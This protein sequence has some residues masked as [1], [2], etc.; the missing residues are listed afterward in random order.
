MGGRVAKAP[1]QATSGQIAQEA[2]NAAG[3]FGNTDPAANRSA[4]YVI[5]SPT[6]T[7]PDNYENGGFC[8]W[9]DYTGDSSAGGSAYGAV[10]FTNL[11]YIPDAG[12]GCGQNFVNSGSAGTLDGVSIVEGHEYAETITDPTA[13]G[14]RQSTLETRMATSA[15]GSSPG[16][17]RCR[18]SR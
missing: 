7:N 5:V 4:Q 15:P 8:A 3:H 11:P 16:R 10:A 14:W 17:A 2:L 6:G 18:T 12:T 9:H 13:G 1:A